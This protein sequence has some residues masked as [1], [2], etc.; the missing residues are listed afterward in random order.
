MPDGS[1]TLYIRARDSVGNT[2]APTGYGFILDKNSPAVTLS[3]ANPMSISQGSIFSDPGARWI[4]NLDGTG[5]ISLATSGSVN[6]SIVGS[7]TLTYEKIDA[8]GNKGSTTRS[9]NVVLGAIN[10]SCGTSS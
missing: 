8:A 7:Y 9:V 2:S 3:G 1:H 10:G 4:D 6:T 5:V